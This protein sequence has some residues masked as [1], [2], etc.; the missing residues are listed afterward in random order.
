MPETPPP[1]SE[2]PAL[3]RWQ[4]VRM[5][6]PAVPPQTL[7][8]LGGNINGPSLIRVPDWLP[9]QLGRY[10]LYFAHHGGQNIRLAFAD[11]LEGPWTLWKPGTL[12]L[13]QTPCSGHI[14]SPDVHVDEA[15][16]ELRMYF[17]GPVQRPGTDRMPQMSLVA[18][19]GDG[20]NFACQPEVLGNSYFRL[21][22]RRDHW[23]AMARSGR[24]YRSPDGFHPF[25][26]GPNPFAGAPLRPRHVALR[27]EGEVLSVFHS[28]IGAA[29]EHIQVSH[30]DVRGG[31]NGWVPSPAVSLLR[32]ERPEE[33]AAL[34]VMPSES[35]LARGPVHQLRDPAYFR[36]GKQEY[37][38]YTLAGE[39]GIGIARLLPG[40]PRP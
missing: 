17:H 1:A 40:P 37:L 7:P 11:D 16:R 23:L 13:D 20:L 4:V 8:Q 24:L 28:T 36:D 38:L 39:C 22:Q 35:G 5:D 34:P 14:A 2:A 30:I 31:W 33:G 29:P 18:R 6:R 10:H 26:P 21:V 32:P 25:E 27:L 9:G 3:P 19:S 12:R 15:R